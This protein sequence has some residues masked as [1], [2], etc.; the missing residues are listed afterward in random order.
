MLQKFVKIT[1]TKFLNISRNDYWNEYLDELGGT[2]R[3]EPA[4][5]VI[6]KLEFSNEV[7][8]V[9]IQ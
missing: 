2:L 6:E 8:G 5:L 9:Y 4:Q 7:K 3:I 1:K